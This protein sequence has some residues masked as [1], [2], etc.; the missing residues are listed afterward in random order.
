MN[1]YD[2]SNA[3]FCL[4][5][6]DPEWDLAVL[7]YRKGQIVSYAYPLPTIGVSDG[8]ASNA[9]AAVA[10]FTR[11][12]H[13]QASR[14]IDTSCCAIAAFITKKSA[15]HLLYT[16]TMFS[17]DSGAAVVISS[18]GDLRAIH[19]ESIN[20]AE[21]LPDHLGS[22]GLNVV[23]KSVKSLIDGVSS[24]WVYWPST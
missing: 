23:S 12:L 9:K 21:E 16:S 4:C 10:S 6:F 15:H 14:E 11:A 24:G 1:G 3:E 19:L 5:A 20:E 18:D 13:G 17:G 8:I 7:K 22:N 2:V